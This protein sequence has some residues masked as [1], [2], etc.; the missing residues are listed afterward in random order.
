MGSMRRET[1]R[2]TSAFHPRHWGRG[3]P[4]GPPSAS[5]TAELGRLACAS[6]PSRC[7]RPPRSR[8][9]TSTTCRSGPRT[10]DAG[11]ARGA[12][13]RAA[14]PRRECATSPP[15]A[16]APRPIRSRAIAR[17]ARRTRRAAAPGSAGRHDN[18]GKL[19][20]PPK[21]DVPPLARAR[22]LHP[23]HRR[24]PGRRAARVHYDYVRRP[25]QREPDFGVT[26]VN[27]G[28]ADLITR[29]SAPG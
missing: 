2:T 28:L 3:L 25:F 29:S 27:Y 4:Q 15:S 8:A 12:P 17:R 14:S 10:G 21:P 1:I 24:V 13:R 11:P 7:A 20:E 26:S 6:H 9:G 19:T 23:R 5:P 18:V 16:P 22:G